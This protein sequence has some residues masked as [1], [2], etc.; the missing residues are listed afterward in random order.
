MSLVERQLQDET[1]L[2]GETPVP[3]TTPATEGPAKY[4]LYSATASVDKC[5]PSIFHKSSA[6][7]K[8]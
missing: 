2:L 8:N 5:V 4:C 7:V 6:V 3:V 1:E